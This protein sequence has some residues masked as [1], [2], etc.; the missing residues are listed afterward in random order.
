MY[1]TRFYLYNFPPQKQIFYILGP[2]T[3]SQYYVEEL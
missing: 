1:L 2:G 3:F